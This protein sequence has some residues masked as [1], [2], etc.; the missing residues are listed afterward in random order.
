[1][2][3]VGIEEDV[4]INVGYPL[5]QDFEFLSILGLRYLPFF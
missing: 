4:G 1:M 3:C 5:R 2:N